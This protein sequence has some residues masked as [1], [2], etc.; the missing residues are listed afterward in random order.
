MPERSYQP[1]RVWDLPTRLFHW[2]LALCIV[3][4]VVTAK[5]GGGAMDWHFRCGYV[6]LTLLAFRVV[7]GL[8]GGR[9]SRFA[10]FIYAPATVLRYLRGQVKPGEHLD[11]GHNPLGSFSVFGLL[12]ILALQVA[13]GLV[14]DDEIAY[15]GP[16]NRLVETATA[17][18]ATSWH[19]TWGQ[20]IILGLVAL[21]IAAIVYYLRRKRVNLVRP[22]VLG[23]KR[24]PP[25][26]PASAD[27]TPQRVLAVLIVALC[28]VGAYWVAVQGG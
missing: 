23:D 15:S 20:W 16:L 12:A 19:K 24:L 4:S 21:H 17:E 14:A 28:A 3:A 6:V 5:I 22:M 10:S 11:V 26:T 1:V 7:W 8:V 9:W 25:G 2:V 27:G 18:V 13:T